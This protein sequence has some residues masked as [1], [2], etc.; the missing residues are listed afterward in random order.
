M[1]KAAISRCSTLIRACRSPR[2][3]D[4][5]A[6]AEELA[7]KFNVPAIYSDYREMIASAELDA[8]VIAT[9]D[10]LHYPMAMAALDAGLHVLCEKPIAMNAVQA[11]AMYDRAEEKNL[12]HMAYFTWRMMPHYH[13][14]YDLIQQGAIGKL[15]TSQFDFQ[16]S[17]G[18]S[19]KYTWR[20][21]RSH[22][23]G[24]VGDLGAHMLDLARYFCGDI[25]RV[26]GHLGFNIQRESPDGLPFDLASDSAIALLEFVN[27]GHGTLQ[28]STIVRHDRNL[29][30]AS[31]L[32]QTWGKRRKLFGREQMCYNIT[33]VGLRAAP[34]PD[35]AAP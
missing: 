24:I 32:L 28:V 15:I 4:G 25:V 21:D 22:S 9:P 27:G 12:R 11:R 7:R 2:S 8:V 1:W 30:V 23:N 33:T 20:N 18:L 3:A 35:R 17:F 10:D 13:Y 31:P 5:R 29:P 16:F 34:S 14:V 26:C 6:P 19:P